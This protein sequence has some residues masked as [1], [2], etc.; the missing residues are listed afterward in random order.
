MEG[1]FWE[2]A[3]KL[4]SDETLELKIDKKEISDRSMPAG[5]ILEQSPG[6]NT[7]AFKGSTV[8]VSVVKDEGQ[9]VTLD[10]LIPVTVPDV[11]G[12]DWKEAQTILMEAGLNARMTRE[13]GTRED[14]DKVLRQSIA[15][16]EET[17]KGTEI[18]IVYSLGPE[19]VQVPEVR[20]K[21]EAE[22]VAELEGLGFRVKQRQEYSDTYDAGKISAQSV[23][24]GEMA[25]KGSE[26]TITVSR[27]KRP[28]ETEAPQT[29][30][31]VT[32]P[33]VTTQPAQPETPP[34]TNPPVQE[35]SPPTNPPAPPEDMSDLFNQ[36]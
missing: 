14:K 10:D 9:T 5:I 15:A 35:T 29:R 24:S 31:A 18:E 22:A 17:R 27:G 2:A 6:G 34:P 1:L 26:I 11:L 8:T 32:A 28:R 23:E 4:L 36:I 3:E 33:P 25:E 16:G 7:A 19:M 20:A 12:M 21:T 30:P 13:Y